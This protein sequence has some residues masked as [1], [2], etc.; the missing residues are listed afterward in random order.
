[1]AKLENVLYYPPMFFQSQPKLRLIFQQCYELFYHGNLKSPQ[2]SVLIFQCP[3]PSQ[4][5]IRGLVA[6]ITDGGNDH[7]ITKISGHL[8]RGVDLLFSVCRR[9]CTLG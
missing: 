3:L 8:Q 7:D 1:M 4:N 5:L 6:F 2:R 9:H